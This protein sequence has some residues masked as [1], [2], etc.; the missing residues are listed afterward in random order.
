M[1]KSK[2]KRLLSYTVLALG[3]SACGL[4]YAE[5]EAKYKADVPASVL[6]PDT[7][8]TKLLGNLKFFDGMPDKDTIR[9]TYDFL[10]VARAAEAFLNGIPAASVYALLE[11][12][13]EA[14]MT[15]IHKCVGL[16]YALKVQKMGAYAVTLVGYENGGA[17]GR[18]DIGTLVL[19]PRAAEALDIPLIGGGGRAT[20]HPDLPAPAPNLPV[21]E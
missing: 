14:G 3:T 19:V 11:G 9:K 1:T 5:Q 13:K 20:A 8:Q 16:R 17:T 7:V 2:V 15:W 10:D 4:A 6:T 21:P 12:F 18:L